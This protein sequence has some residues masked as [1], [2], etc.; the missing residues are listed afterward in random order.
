MFKRAIVRRPCPEMVAGLTTAKLGP[1][2]YQQAL[3]QHDMYSA[4]LETCGLELSV[5]EADSRHPDS[6]FVEDTAL[7][8]PHCAIITRPGAPSRQAEVEAIQ[9]VVASFYDVLEFITPPGTLEAGD[10]MMVGRHFF[11]GLSART[12]APGAEQLIKLLE[13]YDL[14]GSTV[15]LKEMLHLKTGVSY[16]EH[17]CL[18]VTGELVAE[19]AFQKFDKVEI[20]PEE[21]YAANCVW[22]ND[23]VLLPAGY[24]GAKRAIE[25][26]GYETLELD[27]SE[28]RKLDGGLSCLSLR[29]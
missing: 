8:T 11:I 5:L 29:F 16:L 24:P 17:N 7:L 22:I 2:D 1:P 28:F 13:K 19:P 4:A 23:R 21:A 9:P 15:T 20:A 3:K 14:T 25:A 10:V 6:T 12:N 27:V 18:V 26:A